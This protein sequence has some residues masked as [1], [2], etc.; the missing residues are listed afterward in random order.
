MTDT[1][2]EILPRDLTAYRR[3]NTDI[4]YVHRFD[5]GKPGPHV[6]INALTHGNE[7]CGMV[8]ACALLDA[9][10]RPELGVLSISFANVAAYESFDVSAPYDSRQLV[11]NL[12]RIWSEREL[13]G[14]ERSPELDRARQMRPLFDQ[15]DHLLD[16]HSTSQDAPPFWVYPSHSRNTEV[17]LA[18]GFPHAHLL[19]PQ[20]MQTGTP[21][22]Q[23]G[24][25]GRADHPGAALVVEC[26]QHFQR[27]AG[28][29]ATRTALAFMT[30]FGL[31][32]PA[33]CAEHTH[34][35]AGV[36]LASTP[37]E[38]ARR[39]KLL[40]TYV[41]RTPE[42]RFVRPLQGFEVFAAGELI[43]TDG[44]QELRAPCDDCTTVMPARKIV[45][46]REGVYLTKLIGPNCGL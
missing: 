36:D 44:D 11:H 46:G 19:M 15:A 17:A 31:L 35:L 29:A 34:A 3:G 1:V 37:T 13:D 40:S 12:N 38:P 43:A 25:F 23:Y 24:A 39:Y 27:R 6:V 28:V 2:F 20:G 14:S 45:P 7:F 9:G 30:H 33:Q 8:A 26:G 42:F 41:V 32:T 4:D 16:I 21:L 5:S 10:V 22:I 18:L